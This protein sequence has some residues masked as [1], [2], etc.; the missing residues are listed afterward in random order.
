MRP[1]R[2]KNDLVNELTECACVCTDKI[3]QWS[4]YYARFLTGTVAHP[5]PFLSIIIRGDRLRGSPQ[6]C[7][8]FQLDIRF[9]QVDVDLSGRRITAAAGSLKGNC[10]R[11][12]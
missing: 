3:Y 5:V 10:S 12:K 1:A 7:H 8:K 11:K 2:I 6:P 4:F 9:G